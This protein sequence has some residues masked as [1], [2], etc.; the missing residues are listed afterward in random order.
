M[1]VEFISKWNPRLYHL[2]SFLPCH[3][4]SRPHVLWAC[5]CL[6]LNEQATKDGETWESSDWD[7]WNTGS[8][9]STWCL[10]T[11]CFLVSAYFLAFTVAFMPCNIICVF[12]EKATEINRGDYCCDS[13]SSSPIRM[14]LC[15]CVWKSRRVKNSAYCFLSGNVTAKH[16]T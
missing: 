3:L 9:S 2:S 8:A 4:Q 15:I 5:A 10:M 7:S 14:S 16:S 6:T 12:S 11:R 1:L 13:W